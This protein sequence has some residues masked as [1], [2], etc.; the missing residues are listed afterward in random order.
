MENNLSTNSAMYGKSS[1][2]P[3]AT[4]A[5]KFANSLFSS[6]SLS[7]NSQNSTNNPKL[8]LPKL[9]KPSEI[10]TSCFNKKCYSNAHAYHINSISLN[11]DG[12]TFI[13]SDDLRVNLWNLNVTDRAFSRLTNHHIFHL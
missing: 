2:K 12:E 5:S 9:S 10:V 7:N 4:A 6:L 3:S 11:S 8:I 1:P 13:S